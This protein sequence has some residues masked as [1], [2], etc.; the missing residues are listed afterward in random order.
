MRSEQDE[1]LHLTFTPT[2]STFAQQKARSLLAD[3]ENITSLYRESEAKKA[4]L[5][6]RE[7]AKKMEAEIAECTFNPKTKV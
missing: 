3:T 1:L 6:K 4:A 5:R 7:H 2:I